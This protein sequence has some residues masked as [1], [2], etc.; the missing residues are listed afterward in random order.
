MIDWI[1]QYWLQIFF[2]SFLS[3]L[4]FVVKKLYGRFEKEFNEQ[5]QIKRG[6]LAILHDRLYQ[7]CVIHINTGYI[8]TGDLRNLE[9]M[10]SS[11]NS[12]GGN[13]TGTELF[14]RCKNLPLKHSRT[15]VD[16]QRDNYKEA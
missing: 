16:Y 4:T 14:N 8:T 12:L 1:K 15:D 5:K 6:V 3:A 9:F 10:H 13:G 2:A 7:D 11:Y